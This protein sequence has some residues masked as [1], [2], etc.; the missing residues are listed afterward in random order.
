[1]A[2]QDD[3]DVIGVEGSGMVLQGHARHGVE[4]SGGG[5]GPL[6][7][8][9]AHRRRDPLCFDRSEAV[10]EEGVELLAPQAGQMAAQD[11]AAF[12]WEERWSLEAGE[13]RRESG[14]N[15]AEQ[16]F[17]GEIGL[18]QHAH[19]LQGGGFDLIGFVEPQ[20]QVCG[21]GVDGF[22]ENLDGL[23]V[24]AAWSDMQ[25][26]GETADDTDHGDFGG[27]DIDEVMAVSIQA[28]GDLAQKGGF[29]HAGSAGDEAVEARPADGAFEGVFGL[30]VIR[31]GEGVRAGS[32]GPGRVR[33]NI[34][35]LHAWLLGFGLEVG[36]G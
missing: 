5:L 4:E 23:E 10:F 19:F 34:S 25:G 30:H 35:V 33:L 11:D 14:E 12:E 6:E 29:A 8:I 9:V 26:L 1:M 13:Q 22:A 17:G 27:G 32:G 16:R 18:G 28:G 31:V 21:L 36:V 15:D 2:V 7:E 20:E 3:A 24:G